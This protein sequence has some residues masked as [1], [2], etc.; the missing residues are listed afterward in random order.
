MSLAACG[1]NSVPTKQEAAK[2]K[3]ADVQAAFQERANLVPNLAAVAKGAAEQEKAILT[4]V[5]EAR[6]K[7][8]SVQ[9]TANDLND[10]AKMQQF[11]QAQEQFGQSLGRLLVSV[12][13]YPDLKSIVNYQML[14]TQIEGQENRIRVAVRDY[15]GAVQDYN[16]EVRVFP[17]MIGAKLR[18]ASPLVPYQAVTPGADVAPSLEGKL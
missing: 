14:Q 8:T 15:N 18:G 2:A 1:F 13:R 17:T 16:T 7:A 6:A 5:V 4:G 10:P 12:E 3:W 11:S 9:V